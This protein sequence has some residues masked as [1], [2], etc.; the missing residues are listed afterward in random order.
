MIS[1]AAVSTQAHCLDI[2]ITTPKRE[3]CQWIP[4][5]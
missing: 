4:E 1:A 5:A 3:P 2:A